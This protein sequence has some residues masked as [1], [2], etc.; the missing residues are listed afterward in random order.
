MSWGSNVS[1]A[2]VT[3]VVLHERR[4]L[5]NVKGIRILL[6]PKWER[7]HQMLKDTKEDSERLYISYIIIYNYILLY[8]LYIIILITKKH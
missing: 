6:L 8:R 7:R 5:D 1:E 4:S 2:S 3:D